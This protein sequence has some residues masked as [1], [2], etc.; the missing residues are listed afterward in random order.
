MDFIK[1]YSDITQDDPF[2]SEDILEFL[3]EI[4]RKI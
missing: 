2:D 3:E 1:M 4:M